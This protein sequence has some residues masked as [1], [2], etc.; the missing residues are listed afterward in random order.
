MAESVERAESSEGVRWWK[1][2]EMG[3]REA[4]CSSGCGGGAV[5]EAMVSR[6]KDVEI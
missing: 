5:V 3:R 4:L 2:A 6:F 1:E